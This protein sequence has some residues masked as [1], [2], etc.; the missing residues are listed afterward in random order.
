MDGRRC[1]VAWPARAPSRPSRRPAT[2]LRTSSRRC[3]RTRIASTRAGFPS[4]ARTSLR[5]RRGARMAGHR[6]PHNSRRASRGWAQPRT[7][8]RRL[9]RLPSPRPPTLGGRRH[10]SSPSMAGSARRGGGLPETSA[11]PTRTRRTDRCPSSS[12][13]VPRATTRPWARR[14][15]TG[16]STGPRRSASIPDSSTGCGPAASGTSS[17]SRTRP[18]TIPTGCWPRRSAL[19]RS[20]PPTTTTS[21]RWSWAPTRA[22]WAHGWRFCTRWWIRPRFRRSTRPNSTSTGGRRPSSLRFVAPWSIWLATPPT[23]RSDAS[24]IRWGSSSW[25]GARRRTGIETDGRHRSGST[26]CSAISTATCR[27]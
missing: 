8:S 25:R 21:T 16:W 14:S 17:C 2:G 15:T 9:R 3:C 20:G 10:R 22:W 11:R 5:R 4:S 13:Q 12:V 1:L 24:S 19:W 6:P 23:R 18:R 27:R 7:A 26:S